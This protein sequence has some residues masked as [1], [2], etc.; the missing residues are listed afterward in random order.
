MSKL[1]FVSGKHYFTLTKHIEE[2]NIDDAAVIRLESLCPFPAQALQDEIK[3]YKNAKTFIWS[4]EEHRNMGC[5]S[6]VSPRFN[7][8]LGVQLSYAGRGELCQPAVGVGQVHQQEN[9]DILTQT[10]AL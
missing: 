6:F 1:I 5:W 9:R 8:L 2:N 3:S 7:N 4:Q 10:F